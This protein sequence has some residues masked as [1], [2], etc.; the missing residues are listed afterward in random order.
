MD[1]VGVIC[2]NT[3]GHVASGASSGG[4]ALKVM[5]AFCSPMCFLRM[6]CGCICIYIVTTRTFELHP[7]FFFVHSY[8]WITFLTGHGA[9]KRH[10]CL[11]YFWYIFLMLILCSGICPSNCSLI[12]YSVIYLNNYSSHSKQFLLIQI[13]KFWSYLVIIGKTS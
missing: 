10:F 9:S 4:I 3:Q 13:S 7:L 6:F 8:F 11:V 2:I 12:P 5:D 1:T